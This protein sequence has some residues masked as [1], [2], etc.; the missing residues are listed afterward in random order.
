MLPSI[1]RLTI[2][3]T[4]KMQS[5]ERIDGA[6]RSA[7]LF[8]VLKKKERNVPEFTVVYGMRSSIRMKPQLAGGLERTYVTSQTKVVQIRKKFYFYIFFPYLNGVQWHPNLNRIKIQNWFF[9]VVVS[10]RFGHPNPKQ[11]IVVV[12]SFR[13]GQP[14]CLPIMTRFS[15]VVYLLYGYCP[16]L[17]LDI[18]I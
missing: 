1:A 16:F 13:F 18:Q 8:C 3:V 15:V 6:S 7:K 12:V 14:F 5:W 9:A 17:N 10:F 11:V 2:F 4:Q